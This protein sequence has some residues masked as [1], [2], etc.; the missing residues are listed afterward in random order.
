MSSR[1][2]TKHHSQA[3]FCLVGEIEPMGRYQRGVHFG[4]ASLKR[5]VES[6]KFPVQFFVP[7][8]SYT[9]FKPFSNIL[10][11]QNKKYLKKQTCV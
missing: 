4:A 10:A 2:F 6:I 8:F 5:G 1:F 3:T 7:L 9:I 11:A